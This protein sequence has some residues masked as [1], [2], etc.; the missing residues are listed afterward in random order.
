MYTIV[1]L[2]YTIYVS[3]YRDMLNISYKLSK[4]LLTPSCPTQ[5]VQ[6]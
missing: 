3:L 6:V 2:A 5:R 1:Y 4:Q